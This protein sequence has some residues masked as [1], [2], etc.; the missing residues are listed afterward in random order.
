MNQGV[1]YAA[2]NH[3]G[4]KIFSFEDYPSSYGGW[5]VSFMVANIFCEVNCNRADSLLSLT[6]KNALV[7][8]N[9]VN[10]SSIKLV[11]DQLEVVKVIDWI[12][13]LKHQSI[14]ELYQSKFE[15][16]VF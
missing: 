7:G 16:I 14:T 3:V 15:E 1:L 6:S 5:R 13:T 12:R 2:L 10:I 4:C 8:K 9:T 11:S